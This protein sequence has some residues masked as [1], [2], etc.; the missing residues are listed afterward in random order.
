MNSRE[1]SPLGFSVPRCSARVFPLIRD[2]FARKILYISAPDSTFSIFSRSDSRILSANIL[3]FLATSSVSS[4]RNAS[5]K[6]IN[7]TKN[8]VTDISESVIG[9]VGVI[10]LT[11]VRNASKNRN[12][13]SRNEITREN[14]QR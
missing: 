11:S 4:E 7:T 3:A 1:N 9:I 14:N 6:R 13:F 10:G 5:E 2:I 8:V 12:F